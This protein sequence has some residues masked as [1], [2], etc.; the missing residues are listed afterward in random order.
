MASLAVEGGTDKTRR[1]TRHAWASL[2]IFVLFNTVSFID[3]S[4]LSVLVEPIQRDLGISDFQ[5]SLLLGPAFG[6]FYVA[7]GFPLGWVVDRYSR[8]WITFIG[9]CLWGIS[10][11]FCGMAP[12]FMALLTAR[13]GVAVGESALTPTAHVM[14]AEEFPRHRLATALS[15][16]TLGTAVGGGIAVALGGIL[17]Q[18]VSDAGI[19]NLPLIGAISPWKVVLL[20]IGSCTIFLSPLAFLIVDRRTKR[21]GQSDDVS[22]DSDS[23]LDSL[24]SLLKRH[25]LL[26]AG[27]PIAFGFINAINNAYSAWVPTFMVRTYGWEIDQV[28]LAWGV[29]H[30]ITGAVGYFVAASLVDRW[31]ARGR[32]DAHTVY[33]I[34]ALAATIPIAIAGFFSSSPWWFLILNSIYYLFASGWSGY[35]AALLQIFAPPNLRGR[36]AATFLG[37]CTIVGT[38]LGAPLTGWFTDSVFQDKAKLGLSLVCSTAIFTPLCILLL[39]FVRMK[40]KAMTREGGAMFWQIAATPDR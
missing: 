39:L 31:Y 10:T 5:M 15:V 1:I 34:I 35:A 13:M 38:G 22:R 32:T 18:A 2:G 36:V 20:I 17:T 19:T 9:V 3:R 33:P 6:F 37:L 30:S 27:T 25:W 14:I 28:G 29:Q 40:V 24:R 26:F 11:A 7:C 16:F 21:G 8:R 12:T 4:V 23:E